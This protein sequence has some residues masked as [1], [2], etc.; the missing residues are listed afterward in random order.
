MRRRIQQLSEGK[1][2]YDRP[3]LTFSTDRVDIEVLEGKD[4]TGDFVITSANHVPMRGIIYTSDTRM[5]C[6]TPQ[7]EGEEVRI[8][9]QYHSNG[10]VEGDIQKGEFFVICNQGEYNLSFVVS[11]SRLYAETSVGKVRG[12]NDFALL[13][14]QSA[15]E[16]YQLFYS[17]GFRNIMK[18]D[19][20]RELLLYEGMCQGPASR[21]KVEEFL[22]GIRK[23][24]P[25][26][27]ALTAAEMT[28]E[29][30]MESRRE[31]VELTK[32]QWGYLD[33]EVTSD[34]DF[35]E[36]ERRKLTEE[37][38]IGSVCEFPYYIREEALHAGWNFGRLCFSFPGG[39]IALTVRASRS[40]RK[41][42]Q[43]RTERL[44]VKRG[45]IRL[46][47]LY[48]DY[49]LRK[50]VTGVWAGRSAEVLEHLMA[51]CPNEELYPLMKAQAL[52]VNKQRQEAA[53]ILE[54]YKRGST[55]EH[56][57][58][59]DTPVWGYYLYLC[60]L[61]EREPSYVD[62][63][64]EEIEQLSRKYPD[65][66]LLFWIRLF[67][68]E[69]YYRDHA[70]RYK[71][72][73]QWMMAG[74]S[75]SPFLYLEAYYLLWQDPY[76]LRRMGSFEIGVLDWARK[77]DAITRDLALQVMHIVQE[78]KDFDRLIYRILEACF[79][80]EQGDEMLSVICGYLIKGQCYGTGYHHWF[81]QGIVRELR[82]TGLY[83]AYLMSMDAREVSAVPKMIQMYFQYDS[84]L[85]YQ[86]KAVLFV[87]I[88]AGKEHQPE[89]YRK[90]RRTMEQFA[91]EQME[92]GHI[93]DNLAVVY[94]EMLRVGVL[95]D[96]LA[97]R[98]AAILFTHKLTCA[99]TGISRVMVW[100]E[101]IKEPQTVPVVNGVAYVQVYTPHYCVLLEDTRGNCFCRESAFRDEAMMNPA[102][103]LE[104]CLTFAPDESAYLLY[105]LQAPDEV[106][107]EEERMDCIA[108]LLGLNV[109]S[110]RYQSGL[111]SEALQYCRR[112]EEDP[113]YHGDGL[114]RYLH[115]ADAALLPAADK[116]LL[117][118]LYVRTH[119]L[120]EAY[121]LAQLYGYDYM[122]SAAR[123]TLCS[124]AITESGFEEDDFLSG[125]A[126]STFGLGKYNDILLIYLCKY[127]S[128][129]TRQ[130]AELWK[131]AGAFQID[132]FDLE[133]RI[134]T[135]M[136]YTT[137]YTPYAEQIYDSYYAGGGRELICMA[138][139]SY[140]AHMYLTQ[141]AI[142]P[143]HVFT[144]VRDRVQNGQETNDACRLGLLK[145]LSEREHMTETQ[146]KLADELLAVYIG[147]G[148]YFSFYRH[149]PPEFIQKYQLYDKFFLEYHTTPHSR[150]VVHFR[151][152]EEAYQAED[153]A[154]VYDGIY[155]RGFVLF[156][157]ET[158]QYYLTEETDSGSK[159]V[160][161]NCIQNH[162]ILPSGENQ[163]RYAK[164]NEIL[165]QL[166]LAD[167]G[168]L[169]HQMKEYYGML[170]V[171][172]EAFKLL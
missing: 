52:I 165:L 120:A 21:Q 149:L 134:L 170:R 111:M 147:R 172:E 47:Q 69:G 74:K 161:S 43:E 130:M 99:E 63:L 25:V 8:R 126:E 151:M 79:K 65:D 140:F 158:V 143:A 23:K 15:A 66:S 1:F 38:F 95:N 105:A 3:L 146:R 22:I 145:Y 156:F 32:S 115:K 86:Q 163:G 123:V 127:Y 57:A 133:E 20:S 128:G 5:E 84:A 55:G 4:H 53:W 9:Y 81:E 11:V 82:L 36:P 119:H 14:K 73:E 104:R 159:V 42:T 97:H 51:L 136:L 144:Q 152:G 110:R 54:E 83:E 150:V 96:E 88:I 157:G 102:A 44:E 80:V 28:C 76:L 132:T 2:S 92:A 100:H 137:E 98:L 148:S 113:L 85:S 91:M 112:Q 168:S 61:M 142:V 103:Y 93:S 166:T 101:E 106:V 24:Q 26:E 27:L 167:S 114:E 138:Y 153:L 30:V 135:Q 58:R 46:L 33:I 160:E 131:A 155:V 107:K 139:L 75:R 162:N 60:T 16:A 13:A 39:E 141:D 67:V 154:E 72:I 78:Q 117:M 121:A 64:A 49:R 89:V 19:E 35:L 125:L 116:R 118:E 94:D 37:D 48:M 171:T 12:L 34:A 6:L 45:R 17:P 109:V 68:R 50:I 164:L 7:F 122:G 41:M 59:R 90:Y 18:G 77:Q 29:S 87:N 71:A 40:Q 108:R 62:R 56:A 169:K 10:L 124:Y 129:A 70:K 31:I